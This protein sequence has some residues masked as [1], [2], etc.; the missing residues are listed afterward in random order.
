M[1]Y[2]PSAIGVAA[3]PGNLHGAPLLMKR[4]GEIL[5]ES[6]LLTPEQ[7]NRALATAAANQQR[8]G[9]ALVSI[10]LLSE[11]DIARA[12]AT[13]L[14]LEIVR[15]QTMA[16]FPDIL[17]LFPRDLLEQYQIVPI[18]LEPD[19]LIVATADPTNLQ[20]EDA[21]RTASGYD[22]GFVIALPADIKQ[23]LE[24]ATTPKLGMILIQSGKIGPQQVEQAL[25]QAQA[26]GRRLGEVLVD[27]GLLTQADIAQAV[28]AQAR[29]LGTIL[30]SA[31]LLSKDQVERALVIAEASRQRLGE[32]IIDMGLLPEAAIAHALAEQLGLNLANLKSGTIPAHVISLLPRQVA[33]EFGVIPVEVSGNHLTVAT[34]DP[35]NVGVEDYLRNTTK[36]EITFIVAPSSDIGWA[37]E[38]YYPARLAAVVDELT[39]AGLVRPPDVPQP[40]STDRQLAPARPRDNGHFVD[41]MVET[42]ADVVMAPSQD[43]RGGHRLLNVRLEVWLLA[44]VAVALMAIPCT[45]SS[46]IRGRLHPLEREAALIQAAVDAYRTDANVRTSSDTGGLYGFPTDR[47]DYGPG[48]HLVISMPL[49]LRAEYI[50]SIPASASP[51]NG[52]TEGHYIWVI[53][54]ATGRV[55]ACQQATLIGAAALRCVEGYD[56]KYP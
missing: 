42:A 11:I 40:G 16:I 50:R 23:T 53:E 32:A 12:L 51:A 46:L 21:L 10:G 33:V 37:L 17:A 54:A 15:L 38:K 31:G 26:T 48:D 55:K 25:E 20:M 45:A 24:E 39:Q 34:A 27:E 44:M 7:L 18:R 9:E 14:G 43:G 22:I 4:L 30:V 13:Q 29:K 19:R 36:H 8:L 1:D 35:T 47:S 2:Q 56:G 41:Q 3:Q 6:G 5:V 52:G 28:R 49:L